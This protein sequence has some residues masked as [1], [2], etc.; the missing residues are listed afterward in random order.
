MRSSL[1]HLG[2]AGATLV[3][4]M[5]VRDLIINSLKGEKY[6]NYSQSRAYRPKGT[7][8]HRSRPTGQTSRCCYPT[9][10]WI[11]SNC[12]SMHTPHYYRWSLWL[13]NQIT[14]LITP[15]SRRE[16]EARQEYILNILVIFSIVL[17]TIY[18]FSV[19]TLAYTLGTSRNGITIFSASLMVLVFITLMVITKIGYRKSAAW[20]FLALL[21]GPT[22]Y[23]IYRWGTLLPIPLLALSLIIIMTSVLIGTRAAITMA[24]GLGSY[25]GIVMYADQIGL[26][27]TDTSWITNALH[28]NYAIELSVMLLI[29]GGISWLAHR[30]IETSLKRARRSEAQV[31]R[32]RNTM[33]ERIHDR[34]EQLNRTHL[35]HLGTMVRLA[36]IGK[37]SAGFF[38]DLIN[39][40]TAVKLYMGNLQQSEPEINDE[41]KHKIHQAASATDRLVEFATKMKRNLGSDT[42]RSIIPIAHEI[43]QT[44]EAT[45]YQADQHNIVLS[46]TKKS[47]INHYCNALKFHRA[48][49]NLILNAIDACANNPTGRPRIVTI[50]LQ[51]VQNQAELIIADTGAGINSQHIPF[52][53]EPFFTTK[54]GVGLGLGLSITKDILDQ[55]LHS[56]ITVES[57][58]NEGTRMIIRWQ[59]TID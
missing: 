57:K 34:T 32:E 11:N 2:R 37:L 30:E 19:A 3:E 40:L 50:Q 7:T 58:L 36:E 4:T 15:I 56:T 49:V 13:R 14:F 39:P 8:R 46:F 9:L 16:D 12:V 41:I 51:R 24:I 38:H 5:R 33:E 20:I 23:S 42:S 52:L 22:L 21:T 44:L 18:L 28:S 55:E 26:I 54:Q 31:Q 17:S 53:F 45:R 29:T 48:I 10:V 47:E 27:Q 35:E 43:K 59:P 6:G 1:S 25:L